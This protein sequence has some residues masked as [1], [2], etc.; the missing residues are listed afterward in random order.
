MAVFFNKVE[1]GNPGK[2]TD[3]KKWYPVLRTVSLVSE[4]EVAKLISE[5][6]T[7]N[8]KEAEMAIAQF[9]KVLV[10]LLLNS[11]SV[12]LGDWGSF[13]LTCNSYGSNTKADVTA[14]NITKVNLRFRA[15]ND[16]KNEIK[17]VIFKA[18]ET[19]ST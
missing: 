13:R 17:K 4:K 19:L 5:E 1:K 6:T 3:P 15:G 7:L 8:Y 12:Q 14:Q 18:A 10:R 9:Q 11:Y 2:P 16:L